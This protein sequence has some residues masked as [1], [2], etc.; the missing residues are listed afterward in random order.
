[1]KSYYQSRHAQNYN[2]QWH[3]FTERTLAAVLPSIE[4]AVLSQQRDHQLRILDVGCGT[5]SLLRRLADHF[6]DAELYGIDASEH[7]LEQAQHALVDTPQSHLAQVEIGSGKLV[8]LPFAPSSFDIITC[9]NT[10]H[11]FTDPVA[12]LRELQERLVP[13]GQLVIEDYMLRSFPLP[14]NA[15][16]CVIK[17]YD[18]QHVRLYPPSSIQSISQQ[19]GLQVLHAHTFPIDFFC[20]G[21][22]VL[23]AALFDVPVLPG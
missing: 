11:Y 12:T 7:M 9:T 8:N 4:K 10:L 21:W 2:R 19:L 5:G 22:V 20:R 17:L 13:L 18:P 16:E 23:L 14:W 15:F 6:P 3:T 1:M